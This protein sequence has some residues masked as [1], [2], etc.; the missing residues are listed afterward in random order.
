MIDCF[1][2]LETDR[3]DEKDF[4][5]DRFFEDLHLGSDLSIEIR[6]CRLVAT[7]SFSLSIKGTDCLLKGLGTTLKSALSWFNTCYKG[8]RILLALLLGIGGSFLAKFISSVL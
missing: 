4:Y 8:E 7:Y 6:R 3:Y 2:T 5:S 1:G